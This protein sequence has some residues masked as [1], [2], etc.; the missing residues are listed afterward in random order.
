MVCLG[1]FLPFF[2]ASINL[3]FLFYKSEYFKLP[4]F[5]YLVERYDTGFRTVAIAIDIYWIFVY[6]SCIV[7]TLLLRKYWSIFVMLTVHRKYMIKKYLFW[8]FWKKSTLWGWL[9]NPWETKRLSL[10]KYSHFWI[11]KTYWP[12]LNQS[13]SPNYF[14]FNILSFHIDISSLD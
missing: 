8:V 12:F 11:H 9:A 6:K 3:H 1:A 5:A 14:N 2:L 4:W 10:L 7:Y 13:L